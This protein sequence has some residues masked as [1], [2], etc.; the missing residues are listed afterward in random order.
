MTLKETRV[1]LRPPSPN[2]ADEF[3]ALVRASRDFLSPWVDPP[4]DREQFLSYIEQGERKDFR[5]FLIRLVSSGRIAGA[6]NL[7]QISMGNFCSA[8]VGIWIS[9]EHSGQGVMS[10]GLRELF[11]I[12]FGELGLHRLEFNVQPTNERCIK[13][14]NRLGLRREGFSPRYLRINGQWA[15]HDRWAVCAEDIDV[16]K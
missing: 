15:D 1:H 6:I 4:D 2:D 13:L 3:I 12:A 7:S 11:Q 9:L 16:L 10:A 5:P 14:M 8:Y